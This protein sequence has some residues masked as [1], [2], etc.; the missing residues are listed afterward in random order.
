MVEQSWPQLIIALLD[1]SSLLMLLML[2]ALVSIGL[3]WLPSLDKIR[4]FL[5]L[6]FFIKT[7]LI[8]ADA[9]DS[10]FA[11]YLYLFN[12]PL[13][14]LVGP[15]MTGFT[16]STLAMQ[17]TPLLDKSTQLLLLTGYLI[18]SPVFLLKILGVEQPPPWVALLVQIVEI[19]FILLF[20]VSSSFHFIRMLW[21][22]YRGSLY[23]IGYSESTYHWL[24]GV[25]SGVS[26][27]W[28]LLLHSLIFGIVSEPSD[29]VQVFFSLLDI[30]VLFY[31][32]LVTAKYCKKPHEDEEV[33]H[34]QQSIK[35]QKTALTQSQ[36]N[37][38]L[39][40]IDKIMQQQKLFL[41]NS[42]N[43]E[44]LAALIS[45]QP[46]YVSQAINQ[47]RQINFY[48]L[49]A[50]CRIDYAKQKLM[51]DPNK[52]V[53]DIAMSAG[54]NAKSTFNNTFKKLTGLTPSQ[55]RKSS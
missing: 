1:F 26:L 30:F 18:I 38:I 34:C 37:G 52:S 4:L 42:L 44:K 5:G 53:L 54:F 20:V 10:S 33:E 14:L 16:R 43:I 8:Y 29:E 19:A 24:K 13:I 2:L 51:A 55:F 9:V 21:R 7:V 3:N 22:L 46:Q 11:E 15:V 48:E 25:W 35:Y 36:A 28:L 49:V 40:S 32:T 47:Y 31:I 23:T 27:I 39:E 12:L 45:S 17:K 6:F 50:S 41:D